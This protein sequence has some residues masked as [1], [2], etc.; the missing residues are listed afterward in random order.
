MSL[1]RC[2][3]PTPNKSPLKFRISTTRR[4][5]AEKLD[6]V[7]GG[8]DHEVFTDCMLDVDSSIPFWECPA[9]RVSDDGEG[10]SKS[11]REIPKVQLR[12]IEGPEGAGARPPAGR[13]EAKGYRSSEERSEDAR[14][15]L[16][17][18]RRT[19]C[20]Q[21]VRM[22]HGSLITAGNR[23]A[24]ISSETG[25][26]GTLPRLTRVSTARSILNPPSKLF[27]GAGCLQVGRVSPLLQRLQLFLHR[28]RQLWEQERNL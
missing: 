16:E 21:N 23:T 26:Q 25:M 18:D 11:N 5:E 14:T 10:R 9:E 8:E 6:E 1:I 24:E 2:C 3:V 15:V 22:R 7:F 20:Q 27:D 19:H 17:Q 12:R 28:G 13:D 4:P